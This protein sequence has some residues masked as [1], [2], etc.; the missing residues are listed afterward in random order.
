MLNSRQNM[1]ACFICSTKIKFLTFD[2]K[3]LFISLFLI[4]IENQASDFIFFLK[5]INRCC[6]L[7]HFVVSTFTHISTNPKVFSIA[8]SSSTC[9]ARKIWIYLLLPPFQFKFRRSEFFPQNVR[10]FGLLEKINF[11]SN[12]DFFLLFVINDHKRFSHSL[13]KDILVILYK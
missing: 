9:S 1:T 11:L 13:F 5:L 3:L 10:R 2:R 4:W 7:Q 8:Y 12:F 6:V